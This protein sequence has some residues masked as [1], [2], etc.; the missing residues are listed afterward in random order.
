MV[1]IKDRI[2]ESEYKYNEFLNN[3]DR[4]ILQAI[5][6]KKTVTYDE[7]VEPYKCSYANIPSYIFYERK[8][9]F[10][11]KYKLEELVSKKL[12]ITEFGIYYLSPDG[13]KRLTELSSRRNIDVYKITDQDS[14]L[15]YKKDVNELILKSIVQ[16]GATF[17]ELLDILRLEKKKEEWHCKHC[18][19]NHFGIDGDAQFL[20]DL[21]NELIERDRI[22]SDQNIYKWKMSKPIKNKEITASEFVE[23][24]FWFGK[25]WV[26][27]NL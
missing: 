11:L 21:L 25:E 1:K 5:D 17:E 4:M 6:K 15:V 10:N 26:K 18:I 8:G 16:G 9:Y 24:L 14:F 22:Y 20:Q 3:A 7:L 27:R 19:S 23:G 13:R 12:L 2:V